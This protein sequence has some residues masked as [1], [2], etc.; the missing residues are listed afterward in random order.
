MRTAWF[1]LFLPLAA[2]AA[3]PLPAGEAAVWLQR[4]A[5]SARRMSYEGVFVFRNGPEMHTLSVANRPV[6]QSSES[7]LK[8]LDGM[9]REVRCTQAGAITV[10][11]DGAQVRMEKRLSGRHF[12]DL[13]PANAA[14]LANWYAVKLGETARVAG[15]DCTEVE[16]VPKDVFRWGYILC[17][18]KNSGLPLKAVMVNEAGLPLTQFSFA[19]LKLGA[20]P[21]MDPMP[22]SDM[23]ETARP[24]ASERVT[25]TALP[26]GYARIAAVSRQLPNKPGQVEHWVFSDGLTHISLFLEH[27]AKPVETM[28][29][30]SRPGDI[31]MLTRQVGSLQATVL[32][33]APWPAVEQVAMGLEVRK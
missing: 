25:V 21:R 14:S 8:A 5:D 1:L 17:A 31:H 18:E 23:P 20:T 3:D 28:K 9:Q 27:A 2:Q 7:R 22:L 30:Q 12:P 16:L 6:G 24:V 10:M 33:N 11:S 15:L 32:G 19:E 13:L 29:G 26:P 4:M